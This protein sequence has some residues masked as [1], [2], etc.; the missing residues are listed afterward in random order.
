MRY[1]IALLIPLI[2]MSATTFANDY[3][4]S[5]RVLHVLNCMNDL[6]GQTMENMQTCTCR[7]DSVAK[8]LVFEDYDYAMTYERNRRMTGEKGSVVRDNEK[9]KALYS[10]LKDAKNVAEQECPTV[11]RVKNPIT[12]EQ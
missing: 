2:S 7:V 6:G 1:A 12:E 4:T 11:V 8:Q 10:K 9:A 5:D 3:P